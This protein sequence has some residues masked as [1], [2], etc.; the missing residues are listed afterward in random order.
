MIILDKA[1]EERARADAPVRIGLVGAGFMGRGIAASTVA[2]RGLQLVAICS[3]DPERASSL[4]EQ[5][6]R[7]RPVVAET[8]GDLDAASDSGVPAVCSD[9]EPLCTADHVDV[10]VEATGSVGFGARVAVAAIE[11]AKHVVL[12]NAELD[13]TVGP[14][15]KARADRAGVV[16]TNT[17]GDEPA[18]A[19]NLLRYLRTI[20]LEPVLAGNIT[21]LL[22]H[23]RTPATQASFAASVGQDARRVASYAD[24][25]KLAAE[26]AVLANA[27]GLSVRRRGMRGIECDHVVDLVDVLGPDELLS[28]RHVDYVLGAKPGSGVFAVAHS[29]DA[30]ARR[31][32]ANFKLGDGPLYVFYVPWHLPHAEAP[33]TAAR[34][35]LFGDAAVTP[36]GSPVCEVIT[37]AKRDLAPGEILD[38][39]G[40]FT[41]YGLIENASVVRR[42]QLLPM[43]L[44]E[45]SELLVAVA[46]DQ[47]IRRSDVRLRGD[48]L[49]DQLRREH[50]QLPP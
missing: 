38:G 10:V 42:D 33:L 47:P 20:G 3:R 21:G 7:G 32:L 41:V 36:L 28:G 16:I 2:T 40:G 45:G 26:S 39:S 48:V 4:F 25:T 1:L 19:M 11:A 9:P 15:L 31:Y 23:R 44:S 35:A 37:I 8:A 13:A 49:L 46:E 29:D 24:G 30:L 17:D 34:A 12:V 5:L 43:G 22:D 50:D 27:A 18:V 14:A 6:G